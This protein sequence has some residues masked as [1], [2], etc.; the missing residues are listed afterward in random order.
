MQLVGGLVTVTNLLLAAVVG[1]RLLRLAASPSRGAER[2]LAAYFLL[3]ATVSHGLS[4]AL[5]MGWAD[6]GL[7]LPVP[8]QAPIQAA[9]LASGS[10]GM[11][12]V[13]H[14]TWCTFRPR[15]DTAKGAFAAAATLLV[16]SFLAVG[17]SERFAVSV[18]PGPA[19]WLNWTL[20]VLA[21]PWMA[22]ESFRYW[23]MLRRREALG[24]AEPLV[25]NRFL[26]WGSW[27]TAVLLLGCFDP[28]ARLWYIQLAGTT[29]AWVPEVAIQVVRT[30][31]YASSALG[32]L[33]LATLFLTFFPTPAYRR[34]VESRRWAES[35]PPHSRHNARAP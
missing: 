9:F 30:M 28:I 2:G 10:L 19:Y 11:L 24:L 12:G 7:A 1:V 35:R 27:A 13:Y 8:W 32:L 15:S 17:V 6:P 5:Y 20:R 26:L 29:T 21:F 25:T 34:W 33:V 14:F 16:A 3:T 4:C 22:I 23:R 18:L 31:V